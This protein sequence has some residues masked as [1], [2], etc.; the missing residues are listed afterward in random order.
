MERKAESERD[1]L[2]KYKDS[3]EIE[4]EKGKGTKERKRYQKKK[5]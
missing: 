3:R 5:K 4:D 2:E 1:N